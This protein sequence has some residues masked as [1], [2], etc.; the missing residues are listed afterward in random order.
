M[1]LETDPLG[2][3]I[4]E[5]LQK[6]HTSDIQVES[7]ITENEFISVSYLFRTLDQM[8]EKERYA[9]SLAQGR[10]LDV[11]AGSG[12]H[13]L[14]LQ[15]QD[16]N[17]TALD[18]SALCCKAMDLQ[19]V[20][21]VIQADF[22]EYEHSGKYDTLLF[23]MNGFGIAGTLEK[24]ETFFL[25]C[26]SL[27]KPG[28]LL[29]GES[30]DILYMFMEEDGSCNIDLNGDYYGELQYRM[31][32]NQHAGSWFPWLYVSRDLILDVATH[33]GFSLI[34]ITDGTDDDYMICLK[35]PE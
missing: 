14:A 33:V 12:A 24:L 13:A 16:K 5:Y 3:A 9:L 7:T 18:W 29:I 10:I 34:E 21:N 6:G 19:G 20:H 26:R 28:G 25:K 32:Y 15:E 17:V 35:S 22:F 27:L 31:S 23:L 1:H 8:P 11:G 2:L 4:T 30:V